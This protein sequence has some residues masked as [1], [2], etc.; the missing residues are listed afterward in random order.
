[1]QN[2]SIIYDNYNP[3]EE[4][5]R[6]SLCTLGNG[7]FATRGAGEETSDDAIHYPGTYLAGGYNRMKSHIAGETI[8]NEDFVNWPNWLPITFMPEGGEWFNLDKGEIINFRQTLNLRE[9]VLERKILFRDHE[10][11]ETEIVSKRIVHI[12]EAHKAAIQWLVTPKNWSGRIIIRSGIDGTVINNGVKRYA[13]LNQRHLEPLSTGTVGKDGIYLTT[14]T[15]QSKIRMAIAAKTNVYSNG[16]AIN[17][18][19]RLH[20][21]EGH[22]AQVLQF[23]VEKNHQ[24]RI[25]KIV[26]IFTSKDMAISEPL[27]DASKTIKRS[28]DFETLYKSNCAAWKRIWDR[29]DIEIE[30]DE[31]NQLAL[32]LHIFHL[33]QTLSKNIMDLDVGAPSRGLHGEAYRGHIFWDELFIFPIIN[34]IYPEIT[35]ELLMYR[36]RRLPEARFAAKQDGYKGAMFPW[37][38]G[39]DGREESQIIHMN[40]TSGRWL[41]DNTYLQRHV[42]A[43]IA[44]NIW[45]YFQ[46]SNDLEFLSFYG[47]EMFLDIANFLGSKTEFNQD[48]GRYEINHIVGPDEYHTHYPDSDQPGINNNAYTN[49]MVVWTLLTAKKILEILQNGRKDELLDTLGITNQDLERWDDITHKMFVPMLSDGVIEQFEGFDNLKELEWEKYVDRFGPILRLDRV[50]E[51]EDDDVNKYKACKQADALML[52]YLFPGKELSSIFN[53]LG[54]DFHEGYLIN[55]IDYYDKR[56]SH[57][58]TLSK[59]VHSWVTARSNREKSWSNFKDA[60]MSDL[61]D[62]QG[63]TTA[64]GIH[65]GAMAGTVD[66]IQRCYTGMEVKDNI[67]SFNP[68]MPEKIKKIATRLQYRGSRLDLSLTHESLKLKCT[69]GWSDC[70]KI[71]F[72]DEIYEL[73]EGDEKIFKL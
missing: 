18:Q 3:E 23:S 37:Q 30:G 20:E 34:F 44:Y 16:K 5:L 6:E 36:F 48:R 54:Y 4:N 73:I 63:G 31:E 1:M 51:G 29:C 24:Y 59:L 49:I 42:N 9:G 69:G 60:L 21:R 22:V 7:Y 55:N 56:S 53:R 35:R 66:I 65:L 2:W 40:P 58:S 25:E 8:E 33:M 39:S 70:I 15:S 32:R 67:L 64:E 52:F 38:S 11:R 68:D 19:R 12:D 41:P 14:Q 71:L 62:I 50:L 72:R 26:S 57:G 17:P 47:A 46:I 28:S 27:Y 10:Y 13:S 45:Q 61:R 43:A